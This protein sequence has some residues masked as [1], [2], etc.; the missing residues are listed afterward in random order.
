MF[1]NLG[2]TNVAALDGGVNAWK[3]ARYAMEKGTLSAESDRQPAKPAAASVEAGELAK[4]PMIVKIHADWC[5]N[6]QAIAETWHRVEKELADRARI[7]VFDVTDETRVKATRVKAKELGLKQF[8][9]ENASRTGSVAV[10]GPGAV[11][12]D[13]LLVAE[14]D[15]G[16]YERALGKASP[17]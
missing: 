7:V 12:P 14:T 11:E 3:D 17:G 6:C 1:E 5:I 16:V 15:F 4:L 2:Y 9:A 13:T 10:F 8:F